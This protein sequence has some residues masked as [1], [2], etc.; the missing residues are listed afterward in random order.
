MET[1]EPCLEPSRTNCAE[2]GADSR[3]SEPMLPIKSFPVSPMPRSLLVVFEPFGERPPSNLETR[4]PCAAATDMTSGSDA[5]RLFLRKGPG[6]SSE[7]TGPPPSTTAAAAADDDDDVGNG[8]VAASPPTEGA[9]VELRRKQRREGDCDCCRA[10]PPRAGTAVGSVISSNVAL[11]AAVL[12]KFASALPMTMGIG[13][14]GSDDT[15]TGD[16][17]RPSSSAIWPASSPTASPAH[18]HARGWGAA[19]ALRWAPARGS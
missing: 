11:K 18:A 5:V 7:P 3:R 8:S 1:P 15:P 4:A 10:R 16:A 12:A 14:R 17:G 13:M 6:S 9:I 2:G 19:G